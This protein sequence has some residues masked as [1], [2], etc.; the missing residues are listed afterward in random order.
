MKKQIFYI[1]VILLLSLNS[2]IVEEGKQSYNYNSGKIAFGYMEENM[3]TMMA[4]FDIALRLNAYLS[5]PEEWREYIVK[6]YFPKYKILTDGEDQWIGVK[7]ADTVFRI[8]TGNFALDQEGALWKY[9]DRNTKETTISYSQADKWFLE[10]GHT[11]KYY[12]VSNA[13]FE[14]ENTQS[15][16]PKDFQ[17]GDFMISGSGQSFSSADKI[18]LDFVIASPLHEVA[19]N[20]I[21]FNEGNVTIKAVDAELQLSELINVQLIPEKGQ[22][23]SLKIIY[24]GE[25]YFYL[26]NYSDYWPKSDL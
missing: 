13:C 24:K 10:T 12:W 16:Y 21:L 9:V 26:D 25:T 2:C 15:S 19:N 1:G 17:N 23:R 5:V 11:R 4:H 7:Q 6:C 18:T 20:K 14:I 3:V 22:Q 8:F